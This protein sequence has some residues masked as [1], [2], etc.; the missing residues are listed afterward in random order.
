MAMSTGATSS[1]QPWPDTCLGAWVSCVQ[2]GPCWEGKLTREQGGGGGD[3]LGAAVKERHCNR[4]LCPSESH[5]CYGTP[6]STAR[7]IQR[8]RF[9]KT[10]ILAWQSGCST[11]QHGELSNH[12]FTMLQRMILSLAID[13]QGGCATFSCYAKAHLTPQKVEFPLCQ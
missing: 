4:S 8:R 5:G 1:A 3:P 7:T 2:H 10:P 12:L 11:I 6:T 13:Q 9:W